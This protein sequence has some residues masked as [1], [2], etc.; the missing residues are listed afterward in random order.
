MSILTQNDKIITFQAYPYKALSCL[1]SI[2]HGIFP[3]KSYKDFIV[4]M[5]TRV[6]AYIN[7]KN[8]LT[9]LTT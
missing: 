6:Q 7:T 1:I 2:I 5:S 3:K 4:Y 9:E 8:S